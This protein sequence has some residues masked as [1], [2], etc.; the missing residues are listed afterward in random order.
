MNRLQDVIVYHLPETEP[1]W[2]APTPLDPHTRTPFPQVLPVAIG[3]YVD[4]VAHT[5]QT[6]RDL[7]GNVA[8]GILST[9]A[10]NK[11]IVT[12]PE[13]DWR[14][15]VHIMVTPTLPSGERKTAV[16]N[17]LA[18][19]VYEWEAERR[20]GESETRSLWESERR[21]AEASLKNLESQAIADKPKKGETQLSKSD[22][23]LQIKAMIKEL[24][25]TRGPRVT[26][27]FADDTTTEA[28]S[29]LIYM[30]YGSVTILADEDSFLAIIAGKY[31][32]GEADIN[33]LLKGHA[34]SPI[35]V[36]RVTR[37][38]EQV[39]RPCLTVVISPQPSVIADLGKVKGWISKGGAARLL[40][41]FPPS[42]LGYRDEQPGPIPAALRQTWKA[43]IRH[44]LE[45]QPQTETDPTGNPL[46]HELHLEPD[47]FRELQEFRRWCETQF[48]P[49]GTF[50]EHGIRSW[51][52]KLA[53]HVLRLAALLHISR[54]AHPEQM[55]IAATDIA[56]AITLGH[57]FHDHARIMYRMMNAG[58]EQGA[59][60]T[61][62]ECL[63]S[64]ENPTTKSALNQK[65][66]KRTSLAL[67]RASAL[68]APLALLEEY[69]WIKRVQQD[70]TGGRPASEKIFLNPVQSGL[71]RPESPSNDTQGRLPSLFSPDSQ[72]MPANNVHPIQPDPL[73]PTGTDGL[74]GYWE[75]EV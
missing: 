71:K 30:Q 10:A 74:P 63:Q 28:L 29:M 56:A 22:I 64:M 33:I 26:Q 51:G 18:A 35:R 55:R 70:S 24:Q 53:G 5:T 1:Q 65:L 17:E 39:Y 54:H 25:D 73:D 41:A 57:Y 68:D 60:E 44:V 9:A 15:P 48:R 61:V 59:A 75:E 4:A 62:L 20:E 58:A 49:G 67:T 32:G 50:S 12:I 46:P 13:L 23:E 14:E 6:P 42:N 31:S 52:S 66:R 2:E 34:S 3:Q 37:K 8:L 7:A 11:F 45:M 21:R 43:T 27:I 38:G 16:I 19:V 36:G 72:E 47:A 69:G 40:A